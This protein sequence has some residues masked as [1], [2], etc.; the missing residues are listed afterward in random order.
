MMAVVSNFNVQALK[1]K[2][3]QFTVMVNRQDHSVM[4]M[5]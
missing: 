2:I 4:S 1:V 3:L 5:I